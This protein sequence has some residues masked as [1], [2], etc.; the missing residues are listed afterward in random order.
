MFLRILKA[1]G[2]NYALKL[3]DCFNCILD[4]YGFNTINSRSGNK[5]V[6]LI[7]LTFGCLLIL[8][9]AYEKSEDITGGKNSSKNLP[10]L[11]DTVIKLKY[12][13]LMARFKFEFSHDW[14]SSG[15]WLAMELTESDRG[16][17]PF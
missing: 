11:R 6:I 12:Y 13:Y 1:R 9:A 5:S 4:P 16:L 14:S 10:F 3:V 8:R 2:K 17:E 15:P 7:H